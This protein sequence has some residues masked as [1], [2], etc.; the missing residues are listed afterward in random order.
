MLEVL[1]FLQLPSTTKCVPTVYVS[2]L[3]AIMLKI[4]SKDFP[5]LKRVRTAT[6]KPIIDTGNYWIIE[7]N[8]H[9]KMPNQNGTLLFY[10]I[11]YFYWRSCFDSTESVILT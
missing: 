2:I 8:F 3:H 4:N 9:G 1:L 10:E 5:K 11:G 6:I 7:K